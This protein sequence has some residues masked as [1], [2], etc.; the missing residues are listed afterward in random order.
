MTACG[1]YPQAV[2]ADLLAIAA[3]LLWSTL[4][5]LSASL[6]DLPPLFLTGTALLFGSVIALP[7]ARFRLQTLLPSFHILLLGV[8]GLLGYHVLLF[9]AFRFAPALSA[10]LINYL[11]PLGIVVLAP[12]IL[13]GGRLTFRQLLAAFIGFGG[14]V[15]VV[16]SRGSSEADADYPA[17]WV[18]Y[19][20]AFGAALVWATYSLLTSRAE[21]FPTANVGSFGLVSG[22]LALLLH[23]IFEQPVNPSAIQWL[24]IIALGLGPLGGAFYLWDA[25]LKRGNPQRIGLFAFATPLLSTALLLLTTGEP[26]TLELGVATALIVGAAWLG[27]SSPRKEHRAV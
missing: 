24:L 15:L 2:T 16:L 12:L 1:R 21:R 20:L 7:V 5:P 3:I 10:N 4:A 11:W 22:A 25:A 14:A 26:L 19:L 8:Y 18:G 6:T 27:T 13:R 9:T 17:F 23:V